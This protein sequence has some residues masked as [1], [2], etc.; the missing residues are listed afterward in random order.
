MLVII[1]DFEGWIPISG[2]PEIAKRPK[3]VKV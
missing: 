1:L 2:L 3:M